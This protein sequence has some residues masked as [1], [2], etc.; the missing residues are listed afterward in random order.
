MR[1]ADQITK[2]L[3]AA[4]LALKTK[5]PHDVHLRMNDQE[6]L[7]CLETAKDFGMNL[8]EYLRMRIFGIET[9]E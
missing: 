8:S 9:E 2:D 4:R 6:L 7:N 1:T 5:R 3:R